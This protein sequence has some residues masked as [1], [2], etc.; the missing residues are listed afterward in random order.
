[1]NLTKAYI[2][3]KEMILFKKKIETEINRTVSKYQGLPNSKINRAYLYEE[4]KKAFTKA[5]QEKGL[6]SPSNTEKYLSLNFDIDS[7]LIHWH[8]NFD[9]IKKDIKIKTDQEEL[10]NTFAEKAALQRQRL[11]LS[12]QSGK[13]D[14]NL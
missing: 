3:N 7:A 11:F 6:A 2:L 4:V 12:K 13:E 10:L 8:V 5:Y 1:M 14:H 9:R